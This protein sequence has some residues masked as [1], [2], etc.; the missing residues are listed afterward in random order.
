MS[1][2]S[3]RSGLSGLS[4]PASSRP[5]RTGIG[6]DSHPFGPGSPLVLG[7][8]EVAG[9]PGC[10]DI[11]TAMS[12]STLSPTHF[13]S[14][15]SWRSRAACSRRTG[16]LRE[17]WPAVEL[18]LEVRRR[19]EAAALEGRVRWTS[20]SS[21]RVRAWPTTS[22]AWRGRGRRSPRPRRVCRQRE[23]R[24][25]GTSMGRRE[26]DV[27]ISALAVATLGKSS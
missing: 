11:R 1:A 5:A 22:T 6:Q 12:R 17:A 25:P 15:R 14:G 10:M 20:R 8:V 21:P 3:A 4:G 13:W 27:R 2:L 23:G 18:L 19:I 7:G 24:R 26:R 9:A 16:A